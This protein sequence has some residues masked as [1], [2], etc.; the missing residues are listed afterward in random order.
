M[1]QILRNILFAATGAS[2]T[3]AMLPPAQTFE[4]VNSVVQLCYEEHKSLSIRSCV[5]GTE[6]PEEYKKDFHGFNKDSSLHYCGDYYK[7]MEEDKL[8]TNYE[9]YDF[10][11]EG[12]ISNE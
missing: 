12:I 4:K 5:Y 3:A 8:L 7:I 1:R 10:L 11:F 9:F 6:Y 2:V